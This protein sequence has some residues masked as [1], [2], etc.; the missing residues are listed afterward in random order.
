MSNV[1]PRKHWT[2]VT[3][4]D[5]EANGPVDEL[6]RISHEESYLV[7]A[8]PLPRVRAGADRAR[9]VIKGTRPGEDRHYDGAL[10]LL[11]RES[12]QPDFLKRQRELGRRP[13]NWDDDMEQTKSILLIRDL[14]PV[15]IDPELAGKHPQASYY[16]YEDPLVR[17]SRLVHE[18]KEAVLEAISPPYMSLEE[19]P[20][21]QA[22]LNAEKTQG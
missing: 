19:I 15:Q 18:S 2:L 10:M 5:E 9:I 8:D 3:S 21:S 16:W 20:A 11:E 6:L 1:K 17:H 7:W 13:Q 22:A 14:E 12:L 4:Y